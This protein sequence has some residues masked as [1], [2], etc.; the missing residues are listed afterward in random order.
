MFLML[1]MCISLLC[2]WILI[3]AHFLYFLFHRRFNNEYCPA[4][5][6]K[7]KFFIVQACRGEEYDY[8]TC[9]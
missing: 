4:L 3:P 2:V 6:G 8:G 5:T 7:P 9:R 1:S